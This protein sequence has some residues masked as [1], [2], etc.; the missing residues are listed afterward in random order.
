MSGDYIG[1]QSAREDAVDDAVADS[2]LALVRGKKLT[3]NSVAAPVL[4]DVLREAAMMAG[5]D[6]DEYEENVRRAAKFHISS[7]TYVSARSSLRAYWYKHILHLV[8]KPSDVSTALRT[9]IWIHACLDSFHKKGDYA[10]VLD[11]LCAWAI[12]HGIS[13]EKIEEHKAKTHAI[14]LGYQN[15]YW[16]Q[17]KWKVIATE[18]HLEAEIGG[19]VVTCTLDMRIMHPQY[20]HMIVEHKSTGEIPS[21][22]WRTVDP[23]TAIQLWVASQHKFEEGPI[24]GVLFNYLLTKEPAVPQVKKDGEFYA[25]AWDRTT[26]TEAFEK[27]VKKLLAI[28]AEQGR[29]GESCHAEIEEARAK[30]ANDGRFYQRFPILKPDAVIK[31]TMLDVAMTVG[32]IKACEKMGHWPCQHSALDMKRFCSYGRL[33]V[34][35]IAL[36]KPSHLRDEEYIIDTGEREGDEAVRKYLSIFEEGEDE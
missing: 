9:G 29:I 13:D 12:E 2:P 1:R 3:A 24:N 21:P 30:M 28:R 32:W 19:V 16:G 26:T 33:C 4:R 17:D 5:L 27:G 20:G 15:Y 11:A 8:P 18:E 31:N 23:Q 10:A 35:E 36:G 22:S 7:T 34:Q 14:M 6:P 25:N